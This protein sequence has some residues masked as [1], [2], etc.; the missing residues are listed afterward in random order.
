MLIVSGDNCVCLAD[1]TLQQCQNL[2]YS[3][4]ATT[5]H[6][7]PYAPQL[8]KVCNI[9]RLHLC[10]LYHRIASSWRVLPYSAMVNRKRHPL[11]MDWNHPQAAL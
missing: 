3:E 10:S 9:L 8:G 1:A 11:R 2:L 4:Y 7:S 6:Q 5:A